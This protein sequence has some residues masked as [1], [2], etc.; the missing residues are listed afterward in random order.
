MWELL[1]GNNTVEGV[2]ASIK[3]YTGY[4]SL[5]FLSIC[6]LLVTVYAVYIGWKLAKATEDGARAQAKTQLIYS[7]VGI[8]AISLIIVM[9]Q[10]IIPAIKTGLAPSTDSATSTI[11]G[12]GTALT[13][14][15]DLV[16]GVLDI[17]ATAA[18]VFAVYVGWQLMKAEDDAK[19]KQ[20][21]TQ[22]LYT[23][24]AVV[25]VVLINL[26]ATTVLSAIRGNVDST[27]NST[28]SGSILRNIF[29][30]LN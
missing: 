6:A 28:F 26:I 7:I 19:R 21:K 1:A 9:F 8:L 15:N 23:C 4:I 3:Q 29:S 20:A 22:L 27:T 11:A 18:V 17:L 10:A 14:A 25:A 24:V 5:I 12:A 16:G 2:T 13:A 30:I